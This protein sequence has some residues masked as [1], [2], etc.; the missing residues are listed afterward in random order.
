MTVGEMIE[1]LSSFPNGHVVIL[2][3]D[4]EGNA[5]APLRSIEPGLF[6]P[7]KGEFNW[8]ETDAGDNA[9]CNGPYM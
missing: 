6:I 8:D 5:Y 3:I 4:A 1:V 9:V 2:S 7:H